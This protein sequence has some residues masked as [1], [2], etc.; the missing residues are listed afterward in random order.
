MRMCLKAGLGEV[1]ACG[2]TNWEI[3][4]AAADCILRTCKCRWVGLYRIDYARSLVENVV[5][6]GGSAPAHPTFALDKGLTALSIA[7]MKSVVVND[8][9]RD[10]AYLPTLA[11]TRA[12]AI[13]PVIDGGRVVGTIDLESPVPDSLTEDMISALEASATSLAPFLGLIKTVNRESTRIR[14]AQEGDLGQIT[15]IHNYYVENTHLSFDVHGFSVDQRWPWFAE[16]CAGH[17][18]RLVVAE[19]VQH[20]V[21]AYAASGRFRTKEAYDTTVEVTVQCA[22]GFR[23]AGVGTRSYQ[24]LFRLLAA[25]DIH[26]AV[27]AIALPNPASVRLHVRMGFQ[28]IGTFRQV[29]RKFEQYWDVLWMQK[30]LT[31]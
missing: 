9:T 26:C 24:E 16:H 13:I 25:E 7:Q 2:R 18:Y 21:I 28:S 11:D 30:L 29:G 17:R 10:P 19:D 3:L 5:F 22:P 12:E 31:D 14:L 1:I 6:S 23:G 15:M 8:V 27:P 20:G 4:Q